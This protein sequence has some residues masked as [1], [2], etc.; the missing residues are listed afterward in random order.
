MECNTWSDNNK[1]EVVELLKDGE[2]VTDQSVIA[3]TF[4]KHFT[5]LGKSVQDTITSVDC[6]PL[7]YVKP[8]RNHL[9]LCRWR[10]HAYYSNWGKI[11][12]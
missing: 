11:T 9:K 2:K 4:N 12:R 5:G 6:D 7:S 8:C 3:E 10:M 1:M